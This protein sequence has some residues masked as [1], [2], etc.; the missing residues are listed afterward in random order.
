MKRIQ[1]S[2]LLISLLILA[3]TA[4]AQP[5]RPQHH[6]PRLPDAKEIAGMVDELATTLQ[7]TEDQ[8]EEINKLFCEHF[9]EVK[10]RREDKK[11]SPENH[12]QEMDQL[13]AKFEAKVKALLDEEQQAG[14]DRFMKEHAPQPAPMRPRK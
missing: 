11:S 3:V 6:P 5:R 14:F 1:M 4:F 12:R 9:D 10:K 13:K 2:L 8:K 7:L